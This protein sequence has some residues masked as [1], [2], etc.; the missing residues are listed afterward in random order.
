MVL[1]RE[2]ERGKG[3]NWEG[4]TERRRDGGWGAERKLH[5]GKKEEVSFS[6]FLA[7]MGVE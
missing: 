7:S 3:R 5:P 1:L 2:G 6:F 4:E